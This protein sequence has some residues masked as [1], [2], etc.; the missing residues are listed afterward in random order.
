VKLYQQWYALA[1]KNHDYHS[2]SGIGFPAFW[3]NPRGENGWDEIHVLR[4]PF[5]IWVFD[6]FRAET[7]RP[8]RATLTQMRQVLRIAARR[9]TKTLPPPTSNNVR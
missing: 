5:S 4:K 2:F 6:R 3:T 8:S 7:K 1:R 9:L